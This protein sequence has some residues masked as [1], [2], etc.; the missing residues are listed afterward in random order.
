MIRYIHV[1]PHLSGSLLT[2]P[3]LP[4]AMGL[5]WDF[6]EFSGFLSLKWFSTA[7]L[8]KIS[9]RFK[10]PARTES[11]TKS[12][13]SIAF[14]F[15]PSVEAVQ[16]SCLRWMDGWTVIRILGEHP[17][18]HPSHLIQLFPTCQ[19]R[20]WI[21]RIAWEPFPLPSPFW[22]I[23]WNLSACDVWNTIGSLEWHS[24]NPSRWLFF[25]EREREPV[26]QIY[27]VNQCKYS[28]NST[29]CA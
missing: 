1:Y 26:Q 11:W 3:H 7:P 13:A 19:Q 17:G 29:F 12:P 16:L 4:E 10:T 21:I 24:K 15:A 27:N 25:L 20:P 23:G 22:R 6:W 5:N 9:T 18:R 14:L 8:P 28:E 2:E